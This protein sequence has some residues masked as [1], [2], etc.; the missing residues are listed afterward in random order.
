MH[1]SLCPHGSHRCSSN[2]L[3]RLPMIMQI[4]IIQPLMK[5]TII[6]G[7]IVSTH[8]ETEMGS[9]SNG[10]ALETRTMHGGGMGEMGAHGIQRVTIL[11]DKVMHTGSQNQ[12]H[13]MGMGMIRAPGRA[14]PRKEQARNGR[15]RVSNLEAAWALAWLTAACLKRMKWTGG[16]RGRQHHHHHHNCKH[17]QQQHQHITRV[18]APPQPPLL[19]EAGSGRGVQILHKQPGP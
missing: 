12:Q 9:S 15:M 6:I 5:R 16:R 4:Q 3:L 2:S 19:Q 7:K 1:V 17:H 8:G 11:M 14:A 10:T 13:G 18:P